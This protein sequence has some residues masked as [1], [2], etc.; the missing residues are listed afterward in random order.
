MSCILLRASFRACTWMCW[1]TGMARCPSP[2]HRLLPGQIFHLAVLMLRSLFR[3][4]FYL[5]VPT[6][7]P[8]SI[9]TMQPTAKW[10]RRRSIIGAWL[11]PLATGEA[12]PWPS[13]GNAGGERCL[14]EMWAQGWCQG[15]CPGCRGVCSHPAAQADQGMQAGLNASPAAP[16]RASGLVSAAETFLARAAHGC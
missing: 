15:Q 13:Q 12:A 9:Q 10:K 4:E 11:Q 16:L 8:S 2:A 1:V 3:N 6:V 5:I 14:A 7:L